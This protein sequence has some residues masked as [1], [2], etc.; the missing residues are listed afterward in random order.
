MSN[1]GSL[2]VVLDR[3]FAGLPAGLPN[4][5][6]LVGLF[7]NFARLTDKPLCEYDA[8]R[9]ELF[10]HVQPSAQL[11]TEH[12]LLALD[13]MIRGVPTGT[14]GPSFPNVSFVTD[15]CGYRDERPNLA[16]LAISGGPKPAHHN[17]LRLKESPGSLVPEGS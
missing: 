16:T 7:T 12:Y 3:T 6:E 4:S 14:A 11:R 5:R 17:A 15:P 8:A 9:T 1:R 13:H 10:S 2:N